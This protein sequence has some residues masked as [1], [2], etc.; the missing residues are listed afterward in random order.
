M[1]TKTIIHVWTQNFLELDGSKSKEF[2]GFGDLIRCS[3]E[4]YKLCKCMNYNFILDISLHPI[5]QFYNE[6]KHEY[7]ELI[8]QNKDKIYHISANDILRYISKKIKERDVLYF[9]SNFWS[10]ISNA[11][12]AENELETKQRT[13][14]FKKIFKPNDEFMKYI[15]D[16]YNE[17]LKKEYNILHYRLGDEYLINDNINTFDKI[18]SHLLNKYNSNYIFLCDSNK[19]KKYIIDKNNCLSNKNIITIDIDICHIGKSKDIKMLKNTLS[20]LYIISNSKKIDS[21][22]VYEWISGFVFHISNLYDI[23]INGN[24]NVKF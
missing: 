21:Y 3:I 5:S 15:N 19:F 16:N 14:Y 8:S 6:Y 12:F 11:N 7:S 13:E 22:S 2:F 24:I 20:E 4:L 10:S 1:N 18:Y 17:V 23:P 9:I